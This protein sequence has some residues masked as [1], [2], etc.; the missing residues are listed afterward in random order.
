MKKTIQI[1]MF[2]VQLGAALMMQFRLNNGEV[3][4]VLADA[5]VD[6]ASGYSDTHVFSKLFDASGNAT[7]V[8]TSF[9]SA[10]EPRLNLIIGTHYDADHL[11]GLVPIINHHPLPIDEIWLPPVQDDRAKASASSVAGGNM[12]LVQSLLEDH[13]GAVIREYLKK[14]SDGIEEICR[15]CETLQMQEPQLVENKE[16][17]R[18]ENR[19]SHEF[20]ANSSI[21]S[22]TV[23]Y[24]QSHL[25]DANKKLGFSEEED[26][27]AH[28]GDEQ[29]EFEVLQ[30]AL[31]EVRQRWPE[32]IRFAIR[33]SHLRLRDFSEARALGL[34][35]KGARPAGFIALQNIRKA[36]AKDAITA[37]HL[38]AVVKAINAR[39][40]AAVAP[41]IRVRCETISEGQPRYFFW[42]DNQFRGGHPEQKKGE[43]GFHLLGPSAQL[44]AKLHEKIPVGFM[45]L[46]Y[47]DNGLTSGS[48][49]PSNRLSYVMRFHLN[50]E[51]ILISGDAGFS[52]FSPAGTTRFYAPLLDQL[53]SLQVV[54]VAHH[55]G[56]NHRFYQALY[57][58]DLPKQKGWCFLLLSHAENDK[59][60]P[61]AEF[62]NF[63]NLFRWDHGEDVSVLFTSQPRPAK[64]Q[65]FDDLVHPPVLPVGSSI[66]SRGDV[67]LGFPFPPDSTKSATAW[68][69]EAHAIQ[70]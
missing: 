40:K 44:V 25:M 22:E 68:R 29:E 34:I 46:A 23:L 54:Q 59:T 70:V 21:F 8:W 52:D 64:V 65:G 39:N 17:G 26:H 28:D 9:D 55:G 3:V 36:I 47:S 6:K 13:D 35:E 15:I 1:D 31:I 41:P 49:T 32:D 57:A 48:V 5:G 18:N 43:L 37:I 38:D 53:R 33:S 62:G 51:A 42:K 56:I 2:E 10:V 58:A 16:M 69:V 60:R 27:H 24:F 19:E 14:K 45:M 61:R 20:N 7:G 11:R 4:R 12:H 63:V 66:A 50:D 30:Q 67:R